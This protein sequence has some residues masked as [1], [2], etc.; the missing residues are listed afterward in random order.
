MPP[1]PWQRVCLPSMRTSGATLGNVI[2]TLGPGGAPYHLL[3]DAHIDQIS[4]V[5]T[6]VDTQGF[7]MS[8]LR[9]R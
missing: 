3:L 7:F 6:A 5:V 9:R 2:A 1:Q 4:L 8:P